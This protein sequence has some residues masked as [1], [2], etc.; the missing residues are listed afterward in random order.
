[1]SP[2]RHDSRASGP[3]RG[4][5]AVTAA[6]PLVLEAAPD[7]VGRARLYARA[8]LAGAPAD[9]VDDAELVVTELVTNGLLHGL[10]P[11]SVSAARGGNRIRLEV[12]D[13][14]QR[15]PL[16]MRPSAG[17]L[18]G[19]GLGLVATLC[20]SWGADRLPEGKVVWAELLED[21]AGVLVDTFGAVE[22]AAEESNDDKLLSVELGDVPTP[23]LLAA[24]AHVDNVLREFALQTGSGP[25]A[26]G[27]TELVLT[28]ERE[29]ASARNQIKRQAVSAAEG[30]E[31]V[32]H[33]RLLLPV[34]AADAAER[35]LDALDE[36]D[37]YARDARLL[38]LESPAAQR[39]FRRWYVEAVAAQLRAA[40]RQLPAPR[41]PSLTERLVE[42]INALSESR[43]AVA[44][45]AL[46]QRVT[47]AL[48]AAATV[49]QIAAAVVDN[50]T[51]VLSAASSAVYLLEADGV[52][53]AVATAGSDPRTMARYGEIPIGAD[54][55]GGVAVRTGRHVVARN[56]AHLERQF[57]RLTGI[58]EQER[59]L[60]VAPLLT[61]GSALGVVALSFDGASDVDERTQHDFLT[62]LAAVTAQALAR[63][64][65]RGSAAHRPEAPE[66]R[67]PPTAEVPAPA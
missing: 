32:T 55:P 14:G 54:L 62:T 25:V 28:V 57:P 65:H 40:D 13:G 61:A 16:R 39:V 17:S 6:T 66:Q 49:D 34:S 45:L 15:M 47:V 20:E 9:A 24:K 5:R 26:N 12:R 10:G 18:T 58:Y 56:L 35:Y 43:A 44:R 3:A 4:A 19:R 38:T 21:R 67:E 41:V 60:L 46:L 11:I 48:A 27:L 30:G 51:S 59:S 63:A 29:F 2:W 23:L 37:R 8:A 53:R 22:P 50:A 33:L 1:V 64:G 31:P 52:L 36:I 42:E 7:A